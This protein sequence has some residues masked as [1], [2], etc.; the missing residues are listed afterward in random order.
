MQ[1]RTEGR[2]SRGA[3]SKG[4]FG[5][6]WCRVLTIKDAEE[7]EGKRIRGPGIESQRIVASQME[8]VAKKK[9]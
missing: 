5:T 2:C 4:T 9:C 7:R 1:E 8:V 3:R 6:W